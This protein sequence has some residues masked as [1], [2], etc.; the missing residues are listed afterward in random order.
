VR[1][2]DIN[3][4]IAEGFSWDH[5]LL[6]VATSANV[7]CGAHAGSPGLT[8]K[9]I[10]LCQAQRVRVG[11]HPGYPDREGMGRRSFA[12]LAT[13]LEDWTHAL[14][15]QVFP[16]APEAAYIKP[17]GAFYHDVLGD[18]ALADVLTDLLRRT[19]LPLMGMAGTGHEEI[20]AR[21]GVALVREGFA[22]RLYRNDGTLVPRTEPGAVHSDPVEMGRQAVGLVGR[23]DSICVHGDTPGCVE[24]A[25]AVRQALTQAGFEVGT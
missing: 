14:D 4:D 15:D 24:A 18:P 10:D 12:S 7:C 1:H 23:V 13:A 20:A 17:H 11:L 5:D 9:T 22:D 3:V 8:R 6:Q 2:A 25:R 19:G 21:A 16:W